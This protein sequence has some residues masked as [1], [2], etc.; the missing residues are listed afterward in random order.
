[1]A[2]NFLSRPDR[3]LRRRPAA[4]NP[5]VAMVEAAYR[6]HGID[7]RYINC[8]VRPERSVTRC[9]AP[10]PWAGPA[11]IARSRTRSRSSRHLDGL[12]ESAAS[13]RRRQL[14]GARG[15][16]MH[17]R[18]HRRPGFMESL[19]TAVDPAGKSLVDASAPAARRG[20]SRWNPRSQA[21][22]ATSRSSTSRGGARARNSPG[23]STSKTKTK[24]ELRVWDQIHPIASRRRHRIARQ[25]DLDRAVSRRR[26]AGR[27]RSATPARGDD[28]RRRHPEPAAHAAHPRGRGARRAPC[29]TASGCSS[30]R[31]WSPS[32][33][34]GVDADP[35]VMRRTLEEL[36][37][38]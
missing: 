21:R 38:A 5:T 20:R 37:G 36:F 1:M 12:A 6:H 30:T 15:G 22:R 16:R 18:E 24:A 13:D 2:H 23:L 10:A 32:A 29:S 17:R 28:R 34:G 7:A 14:R 19:R 27:H 26:R 35:K 4:E 25:R 33:T 8:E 9:A 3:L 11:S 31:A